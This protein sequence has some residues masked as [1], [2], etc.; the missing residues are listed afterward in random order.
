MYLNNNPELGGGMEGGAMARAQQ[1]VAP[2]ISPMA[3]GVR[4]PAARPAAP[5]APAAPPVA[6]APPT[7]ANVHMAP[8]GAPGGTIGNR[9]SPLIA[10]AQ[11]VAAA[12]AANAAARPA[13]PAA[14]PAAGIDV[15][16]ARTQGFGPGNDLRSTMIAPQEGP[17]R[18]ELARQNFGMLSK[19]LD[20]QETQANRRVGQNAAAFG[21]IGAGMTTTNLGDVATAFGQQRADAA[22]RMSLDAAGQQFDDQ[23]RMRDELRGERGNQNQQ[24]QQSFENA[25]GREKFGYLKD[26]DQLERLLRVGQGGNLDGALLGAADRTGPANQGVTGQ[27]LSAWSQR[28]ALGGVQSRRGVPAGEAV[29]ANQRLA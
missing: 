4:R 20:N 11:Q 15:P 8:A 28:R 14:P 17:D 12:G 7:G 23:S 22:Q 21:R 9:L 6:I 2:M 26:S 18:G 1:L 25:M 10:K 24:G 13:A 29:P 3:P 16:Y 27:M 19:E 5:A